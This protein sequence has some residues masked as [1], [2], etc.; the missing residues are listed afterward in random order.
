VK[1][2]IED[3]SSEQILNE[4][5]RLSTVDLVDVTDR[6]QNQFEIQ[7]RPGVSSKRE[8]FKLC[9]DKGWV[10]TELIPIETRLEDIFRDLTTN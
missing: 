6:T 9:V 3:G 1:V 5:R 10:L 8:L 4:L 7:S 2:R